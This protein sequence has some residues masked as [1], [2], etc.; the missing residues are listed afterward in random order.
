MWN[1]ATRMVGICCLW[2]VELILWSV[3]TLSSCNPFE[4]MQMIHSLR[5]K[6]IVYVGFK[7]TKIKFDDVQDKCQQK[8]PHHDCCRQWPCGLRP[9]RRI[10][11]LGFIRVFK[12]FLAVVSTQMFQSQQHGHGVKMWFV[13]NTSSLI[14][15]FPSHPPE[16][17]RQ[18][19]I[20]ILD[21]A[22]SDTRIQAC[23]SLLLYNKR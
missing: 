7:V 11:S 1:T 9:V 10:L 2:F 13:W 22:C 3:H 4:T 14:Q 21:P 12:L 20:F 17:D 8:T 18:L 15:Y 23:T 6:Y 16:G 19:N 5:Q